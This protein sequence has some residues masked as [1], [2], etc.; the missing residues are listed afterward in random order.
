MTIKNTFLASFDPPSLIVKSVFDC[1][2]TRC[3]EMS[4]YL[5]ILLTYMV[6]PFLNLTGCKIL[7][8]QK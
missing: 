5:H 2:P 8:L 4:N 3:V 1:H 6:L 7:S